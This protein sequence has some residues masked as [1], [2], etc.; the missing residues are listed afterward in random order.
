M[1]TLPI[2]KTDRLILKR[3]LPF[4][5][6]NYHIKIGE[7][8]QFKLLVLNYIN[9]LLKLYTPT[10]T[11]RS[12][13]RELKTEPWAKLKTYGV[14]ALTVAAQGLWNQLPQYIRNCQR[15]D[16]NRKLKTYMLKGYLIAIYNFE[17]CISIMLLV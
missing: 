3:T 5:L 7:R 11:L 9:T 13:N 12:L 16:L 17:L 8:I 14:S 6:Y 1:Y 15:I 4:S 10:E 2:C